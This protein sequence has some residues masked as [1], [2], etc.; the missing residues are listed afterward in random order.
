MALESTSLE[1]PLRQTVPIWHQG[2]EGNFMRAE[3][4]DGA[5][6][7]PRKD[8]KPHPLLILYGYLIEAARDTG[9]PGNIT[10]V[11]PRDLR[12]GVDVSVVKYAGFHDTGTSRMPA[13]VYLYAAADVQDLALEAFANAAFTL[14][15]GV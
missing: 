14:L 1:G 6:W 2:F 7:A 8:S 3:G 10:E 13:R 5:A 9:S 15:V 11:G 4:P 12:T